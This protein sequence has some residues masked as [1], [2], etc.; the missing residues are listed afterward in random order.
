MVESNT[1]LDMPIH[2]ERGLILVNTGN[3]KGKTTAALGVALRA[4]GNGQKVLILQ[5]IKGNTKYGELEGVAK[6]G[7]DLIEIRPMGKGFIFHNRQS[8]DAEIKAHQEAAKVAWAMLE[9][10][11]YSDLWDLVILDEINYAVKYGLVDVQTVITLLKNKPKRL[12][13]ILTGREA[14]PEIIELADTVTEMKEIK[15]AYKK[16]IK[17]KKGI[18]F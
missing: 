14:R 4:V 8:S 6:L 3:G 12:N 17:A 15:H 18:E 2:N 16:G 13:L 1:N 10:E 9:K 11:V 7:K 5:F